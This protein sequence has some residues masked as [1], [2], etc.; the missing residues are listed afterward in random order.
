ML[1]FFHWRGGTAKADNFTLLE[2]IDGKDD[3]TFVWRSNTYSDF[4]VTNHFIHLYE[5]TVVKWCSYSWMR[6]VL[7]QTLERLVTIYKFVGEGLRLKGCSPGIWWKTYSSALVREAEL[8]AA[9]FIPLAFHHRGLIIINGAHGSINRYI[10]TYNLFWAT[11]G[12]HC[13][14]NLHPRGHQDR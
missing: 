8:V 9:P 3:L 11:I 5:M 7:N 13:Y 2:H 12:F 10:S 1:L 4:M 14:L 6:N